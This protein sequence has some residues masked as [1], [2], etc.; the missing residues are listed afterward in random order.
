MQWAPTA[1]DRVWETSDRGRGLEDKRCGRESDRHPCSSHP[2][3]SITGM[4]PTREEKGTG[5]PRVW[6]V[7]R[8]TSLGRFRGMLLFETI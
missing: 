7:E 4:R 2:P 8:A 1:P 3:T 5:D 6:N